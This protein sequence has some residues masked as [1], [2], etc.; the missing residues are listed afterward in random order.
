MLVY[1]IRPY[2]EIEWMG[3]ESD[4][5]EHPPKKQEQSQTDLSESATRFLDLWKKIRHN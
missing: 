1:N 5:D 3:F 2:C 4:Y